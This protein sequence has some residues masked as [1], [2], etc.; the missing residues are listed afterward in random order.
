MTAWPHEL[1]QANKQTQTHALTWMS[2]DTGMQNGSEWP[3]QTD[4]S[5][6]QSIIIY[7]LTTV[8]LVYTIFL[9]YLYLAIFYIF[10]VKYYFLY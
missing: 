5:M 3:P 7:A 2:T 1:F 4:R 10:T 9:L 8:T 6:N